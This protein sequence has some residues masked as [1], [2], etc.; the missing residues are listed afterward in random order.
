MKIKYFLILLLFLTAFCISEKVQAS[1]F[2][3]GDLTYKCVGQDSFQITTKIYRDCSGL[4]FTVPFISFQLIATHPTSNSNR[5]ASVQIYSRQISVVDFDCSTTI[6]RC[7]PNSNINY[8]LQEIIFDTILHLP[9]VFGANWDSSFCKIYFLTNLGGIRNQPT[10]L[11]GGTM[12]LYCYI[13]R[14]EAPKNNSAQLLNKPNLLICNGALISFNVGAIDTLDYDS[15]S[16]AMISPQDGFNSSVAFLSG[17]SL[18]KP[19]IYLGMI[20]NDLNVD[21]IKGDLKFYSTQSQQP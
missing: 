12:A 15:F 10:N 19:F 7:L 11:V 4:T 1:H 3:G 2:A 9:S 8:G 5:I 6:S 21:P 17:F 20:G 18:Q 13:N 16:Y 14:C